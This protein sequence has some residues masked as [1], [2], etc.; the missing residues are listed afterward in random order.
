MEATVEEE[1][2]AVPEI[3]TLTPLD[4]IESYQEV[5]NDLDINPGYDTQEIR[6]WLLDV[7]K[8]TCGFFFT[9]IQN[10]KC[11]KTTRR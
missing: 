11:W 6:S 4:I 10:R 7:F 2:K 8:Q 3:F 5:S 1:K 9:L